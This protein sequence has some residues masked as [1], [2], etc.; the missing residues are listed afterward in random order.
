MPG[1]V[2]IP[3]SVIAPFDVTVKLLPTV[4]AANTVAILLVKATSLL[5]LFES[6]TAPVN[7]LFCVKVI[8]LAP[9][10]KLDVPGT[11]NTP[12]SVIAPFDVTVKLL[13]TVEAANT[14]AILLVKETLLAPLFES[15]TAP[16][17]A[18]FCVKVI[19]LAPALK[20]DVPGTVNTPVSVIA[21]FDVTVKLLPTVEVAN[22]VAILLVK[23]TLLLP[24]FESVTAPVNALFC[25]KVIALAP[26]LKLDVPGTVNTPVSVIA[27][28]DVTVKLLPT[29]EAANTVAILLVKETLLA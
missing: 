18:L 1:T 5:P 14:V 26:A 8:A 6:V 24:L 27:P 15:V 29:V 28:F 22:T 25:V 11:V 3:V 12:V 17:N 2:N 16:V 4:E 20:L 9:A 13:P 21:P 7:A 10:L 19:A 23:A